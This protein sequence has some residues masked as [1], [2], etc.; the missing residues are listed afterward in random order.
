LATE[1][2]TPTQIG[3]PTEEIVRDRLY[4]G[5]EWVVPAGS[6]TI[7]VVDSTTERVI[8][9]VPEG[10]PEDVDRAVKAARAGFDAWRGVPV[11]QRVEAC[12]AI[13]AALAERAGEIAALISAEVGMPLAQAR[14]I[15]AALP[16][17]DFGA[18]A[19]TAGEVAWE[20]QI[21]NSLV[22]REPVGVVG[23]ITPW[24]YPLHQICAKVGP[25]LTAGCSV[26]V[27][28]SEVTPLT[29]FLLAEIVDS[30][31]LPAGVFN[32]VTGFG[33]VVGEAVVAHDD[34]DMVS[35]T[36][37]TRAGR[38]VAE[39]AAQT[40][41]KVAL[42]LGGKSAN[43]ILDD[44]DLKRAIGYGVANC[45]LNSGQT[46]S[47]H[48]RMLVPR[49]KLAEAEEIAK[50]AAEKATPGDPFEQGTRLGPLVS[51]AQRE[52]VRGYIEKGQEEGAKLVTGGTEPPEGVESGY[53]V[54]PT[55]FSE[56]KPDMA[57]AQ[58]EIFGPVL[59]IIPYEDEDEAAEIANSTIYGLD[60]GV[61]SS[62]P[63]RAKAFARRM[64][65]G[66]VQINGATF[67]PIAPFGGFKQSGH[68]REYGRY[69]LEEFLEVKSIQL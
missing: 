52:R 58:E 8:G 42:E 17:M 32:L 43:V 55:I 53:F 48:T 35:F 64:R 51:E 20:E 57:I 44:A 9:H 12:T 23:C 40:V 63:E 65:T 36:G 2:T 16:A 22:V 26:V 34:V 5:G 13:S 21:G 50:A 47:A 45:Y 46:C 1:T 30:L 69:G 39:V 15:Q 68:G 33:P 66:Q 62:D 28:P 29:S 61:W 31:D 7:E 59:S 18:M 37:S 49:E 6:G 38:R 60:G 11:E 14:S 19:Q 4:I 67:N 54:R 56:V 10:T 24:N 27:K 41:K 25:A 3:H